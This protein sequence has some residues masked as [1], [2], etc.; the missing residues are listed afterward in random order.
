MEDR[1]HRNIKPRF[2]FE[3]PDIMDPDVAVSLDCARAVLKGEQPHPWSKKEQVGVVTDLMA[4]AAV[5]TL[6]DPADVPPTPSSPGINL[7]DMFGGMQTTNQR[8]EIRIMTPWKNQAECV[9]TWPHGVKV[10]NDQDDARSEIS[11]LTESVSS[12]DVENDDLN[13]NVLIE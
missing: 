5:D 1:G 12:T 13:E 3:K 2:K 10:I 4:I 8:I 6:N 7:D 11:I 9:S